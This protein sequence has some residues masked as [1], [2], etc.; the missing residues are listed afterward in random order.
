MFLENKTSRTNIV[1]HI[2]NFY[3]EQELDK[4]STCQNFQQVQLANF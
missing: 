2:K 4:T 1:E 3:E